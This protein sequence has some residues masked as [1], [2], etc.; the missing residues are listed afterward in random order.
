MLM[1]KIFAVG[2][3]SIEEMENQSV[4]YS[5]K[6][7]MKVKTLASAHA[8]KVSEDQAIDP[9]LLFQRF[10][11]VSQTGELGFNDVLK[12]E[13]SPYPPS[14]FEAKYVLRKPD[15]AQLQEAIR[16]Y[17]ASTENAVLQTIPTH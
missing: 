14:L 16:D 12:Y 4:L 6:R 3:N 9:A 2:K 11:V 13:L 8:I 7:K 5:Y 1:F 15:K 10:L 17:A